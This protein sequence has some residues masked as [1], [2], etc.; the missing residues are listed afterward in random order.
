MKKPNI[1]VREH[2]FTKLEEFLEIAVD[3]INNAVV[4]PMLWVGIDPGTTGA[5]AMVIG[6]E[7][8]D[9]AA[10]VVLDMPIQFIPTKKMRAPT[11]KEKKE[12]RAEG[13]VIPKKTTVHGKGM[14]FDNDAIWTIFKMLKTKI[15]RSCIRVAVEKG[16]VRNASREAAFAKHSPNSR[17]AKFGDTPL[18]G[19]KIG[20]SFG[21]WNLFLTSRGY[22]K[23]VP[24]LNPTPAVWKKAMQLGP[25][26]NKARAAAIKLFPFL[27]DDLARVKDH[28]RAEALLLAAYLRR[29]PTP[30]IEDESEEEA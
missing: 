26:K 17:F 27:K 24:I 13:K 7:G 6:E 15:A 22:A 5:I 1:K 2:D 25:D 23:E 18:T 14:V 9:G 30:T 29:H 10:A 20:V 11:K 16:Q 19:Y 21:M 3:H 12:L 8:G 4:P 28:N